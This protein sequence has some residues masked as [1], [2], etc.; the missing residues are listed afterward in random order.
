MTHSCWGKPPA[1]IYN[2]IK[3]IK[4]NSTICIVGCSDGKFVFPFL[5]KGFDVT[6]IDIDEIAL[7]GGEKTIPEARKSIPKCKYNNSPDKR[8]YDH[9]PAKTIYI[10]GLLK[11]V[12]Q[13]K[14][15]EKFHLI[16]NDYYRNP[17]AQQFDVVFTSCS[18]QYKANRSIPVENLIFTLKNNVKTNGYLY[19]DYMM[20]LEDSHEWKS[21]HFLRTGQIRKY[22]ETDEWEICYIQEMKKPVFEAAHIDRPEDHFH[23][24]GYIL[25]KKVR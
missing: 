10:D 6:A 24:F 17:P 25:A 19:M 18:I 20:P 7:F 8:K 11:R 3:K 5:R 14:L 15:E 9:L 2:F 22:F 4:S 13:E 16:M 21:E 12:R 1:R 23:R